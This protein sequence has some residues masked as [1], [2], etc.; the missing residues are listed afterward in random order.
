MAKRKPDWG[1]APRK[2]RITY[3]PR[4]QDRVSLFERCKGATLMYH[5]ATFSMPIPIVQRPYTAHREAARLADKQGEAVL[6]T[7]V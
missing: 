7:S 6:G 3:S 2:P 4:T 5:D 1:T